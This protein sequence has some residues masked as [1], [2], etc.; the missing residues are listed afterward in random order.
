MEKGEQRGIVLAVHAQIVETA[1]AWGEPVGLEARLPSSR[2]APEQRPP[3]RAE[4]LGVPVLVRGV[5]QVQPSQQAVG[6]EL[7]GAAQISTSIGLGLGEAEKLA[8]P[9]MNIAPDPG[10]NGA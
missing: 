9:S 7:G 5:P 6:G 2:Q 1:L 8:R 10:V 4:D 3:A